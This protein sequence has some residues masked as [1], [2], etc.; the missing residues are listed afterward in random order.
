MEVVAGRV[1]AG[2]NGKRV[3][4]S[5]I[6]L[7]GSELHGGFELPTPRAATALPEIREILTQIEGQL[8][9]QSGGGWPA[10]ASDGMRPPTMQKSPVIWG[11]L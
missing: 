2:A 10:T 5:D 8:K 11:F 3:L 7:F 9:G 6:G 4:C 1:F